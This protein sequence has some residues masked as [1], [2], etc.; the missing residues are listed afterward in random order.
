MYVKILH[1]SFNRFFSSAKKDSKDAIVSDAI[2]KTECVCLELNISLPWQRD[3]SALG[4]YLI[5]LVLK[6]FIDLI[7]E[8]RMGVEF[9]C[10]HWREYKRLWTP[11]LLKFVLCKRHWLNEHLC[12]T[13]CIIT[14]ANTFELHAG[15]LKA[16]SKIPVNSLD[17]SKLWTYSFT[18]EWKKFIFYSNLAASSCSS[19]HKHKHVEWHQF[20]TLEIQ[21][22]NLSLLTKYSWSNRSN[23]KQLFIYKRIGRQLQ[24]WEWNSVLFGCLLPIYKCTRWRNTRHFSG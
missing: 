18:V 7:W 9:S 20:F 23:L 4:L 24:A 5:K 10:L 14:V 6:Y 8:L 12:K 11:D 13:A 2:L 21:W 17:V 16:T 15:F 22:N 1:F 19:I 3:V